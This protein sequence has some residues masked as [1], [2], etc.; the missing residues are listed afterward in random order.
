MDDAEVE[1]MFAGI[2]APALDDDAGGAGCNHSDHR[3]V[4]DRTCEAG[5]SHDAVGGERLAAAAGLDAAFLRASAAGRLRAFAFPR[6]APRAC[7]TPF[8]GASCLRP[9]R[10]LRLP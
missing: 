9:P 5:S 3:V 2:P 7:G 1:G 4:A 10:R 8:A 6:D